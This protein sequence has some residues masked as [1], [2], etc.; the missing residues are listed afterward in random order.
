MRQARW[1]LSSTESQTSVSSELTEAYFFL[2]GSAFFLRQNPHA[3]Q[4]NL[5]KNPK[6]RLLSVD[7]K[8][9]LHAMRRRI[10]RMA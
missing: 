8:I 7:R 5:H 2:F 10:P 3:K 9:P 6:A 4:G 1:E